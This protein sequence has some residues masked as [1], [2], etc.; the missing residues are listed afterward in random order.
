[1]LKKRKKYFFRG[2]KK[3]SLIQYFAP[4]FVSF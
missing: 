3:G 2:T 4:Q 1:M